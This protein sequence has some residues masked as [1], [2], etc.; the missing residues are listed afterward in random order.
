MES[1]APS[2]VRQIRIQKKQQSL[3]RRINLQRAAEVSAYKKNL[4]KHK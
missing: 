1:H 3:G 2:R 4:K